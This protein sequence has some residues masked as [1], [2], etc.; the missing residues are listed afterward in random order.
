MPCRC[1]T[2]SLYIG[3]IDACGLLI[4]DISSTAPNDLFVLELD[5]LNT[6]K[7]ISAQPITNAGDKP[8]F[9]I[10]ELNE[11]FN[12]MGVLLKNNATV[13]LVDSNAIEYDCVQFTTQLS[14][15][16]QNTQTQPLI[17]L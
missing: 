4:F 8:T 7:R 11:N 5:F 10:S 15:P 16:S 13:V 1:C 17:I 12:F 14:R 9:D 6:K 3:C 2:N